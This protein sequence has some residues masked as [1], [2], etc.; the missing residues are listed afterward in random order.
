MEP[1]FEQIDAFDECFSSFIRMK[2]ISVIVRCLFNMQ[3]Y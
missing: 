1:G 3:S 2:N